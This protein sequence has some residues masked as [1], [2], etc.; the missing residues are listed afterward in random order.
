MVFTKNIEFSVKVTRAY[1]VAQRPSSG[2]NFF[3]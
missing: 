1:A 3:L 2:V